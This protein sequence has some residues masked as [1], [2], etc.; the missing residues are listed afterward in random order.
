MIEHKRGEPERLI[1]LLRRMRLV[2]EVLVQSFDWQFLAACRELEPR[3]CLAVLGGGRGRERP[4]L[5]DLAAY[6]YAGMAHW[7]HAKL[8]KEDVDLLHR[9]GF[10][11]CVYTVNKPEDIARAKALGI[12]AITTDHPERVT[13]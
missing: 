8:R 7:N 13:R 5:A 1:A 6:S 12:D 10:L 11:V 4:V 9:N 3:L 2:G